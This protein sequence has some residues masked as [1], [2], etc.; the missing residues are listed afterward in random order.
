M[1]YKKYYQHT[2]TDNNMEYLTEKQ[3][4]EDGPIMVDLDLKY[5]YNILEKQHTT[6]HI[7]D[8]VI[9]YMDKCRELL[10]LQHNTT[11]DVYVMEKSSVNRIPE[12]KITKDGIHII[13]G[14]SMHKGLQVLLREKVLEEIKEIWDDLPITNTW[15][16]VIDEG[17]TKGQVNWQVYGSRKPGHQAYLIK[18]H[19][20]LTYEDEEW[21]TTENNIEDF[22][23]EK[24]LQRLS[25]RHRDYPKFDM[26]EEIEGEFTNACKSLGRKKPETA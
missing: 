3:L 15:D 25:A 7:V 12:K 5:A 21:S 19:Y 11:I 13:I 6:D 18:H 10:C 4:R 26:K 22:N 2:F 17:V 24:S 9:L 16:E 1:F 8:I 20:E 14:I 23:T